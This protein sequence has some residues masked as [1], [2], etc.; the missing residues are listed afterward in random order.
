MAVEHIDVDAERKTAAKSTQ[1]F[2]KEHILPPMRMVHIPATA[3]KSPASWKTSPL[4][5]LSLCPL[6]SDLPGKIVF[7]FV[8]LWKTRAA[9]FGETDCLAA[10]DCHPGPIMI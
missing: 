9:F 2:P 8:L 6:W 3:E 10:P 7:A 1:A 5:P 4:N